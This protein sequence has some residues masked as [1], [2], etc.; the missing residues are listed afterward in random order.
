VSDR[1]DVWAL[2]MGHR[3][4]D[5]AGL[6]T[7]QPRGSCRSGSVPCL[8]LETGLESEVGVESEWALRSLPTQTTQG[9]WDSVLLAQ[10]PREV[11]ESPSLELFQ[12][13][14]DVALRG[15]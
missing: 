15:Q 5:S 8:Y 13:C 12:S 3:V 11:E 9:L 6:R 1:V 4:W 7:L 14:G 2:G 10:L